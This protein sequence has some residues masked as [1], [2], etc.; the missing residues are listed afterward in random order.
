MKEIVD[1][2]TGAES[3]QLTRVK[4]EER[5]E[6]ERLKLPKLIGLLSKSVTCTFYLIS[7][8]R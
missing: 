2:V 8:E 3:M 5:G 1:F 4:F 7:N 6:A